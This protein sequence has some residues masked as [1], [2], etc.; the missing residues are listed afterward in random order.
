MT[1]TM[2][3]VRTQGEDSMGLPVESSIGLGHTLALVMIARSWPGTI[4]ERL[5]EFLKESAI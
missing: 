4:K 1:G 5:K 2:A 3:A